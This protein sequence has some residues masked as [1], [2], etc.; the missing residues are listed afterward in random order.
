VPAGYT[1]CLFCVGGDMCESA[2]FVTAYPS[3]I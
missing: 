2:V 1:V 3:S